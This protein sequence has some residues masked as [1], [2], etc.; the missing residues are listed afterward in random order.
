MQEG[1]STKRKMIKKRET[2]MHDL[3]LSLQR[4][5]DGESISDGSLGPKA[6]D[7]LHSGGHF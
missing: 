5:A 6:G 2:G 3:L 7:H 1:Q 4:V